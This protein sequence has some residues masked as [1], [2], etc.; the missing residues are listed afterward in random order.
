[1][2]RNG[3]QELVLSVFVCKSLAQEGGKYE[4]SL[5]NSIQKTCTVDLWCVRHY[6]V[7]GS[8]RMGGHWLCL[9]TSQSNEEEEYIKR[10]FQ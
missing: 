2:G 10:Q 3:D 6:W 7:P 4:E 8:T 1:M 9:R 5:V